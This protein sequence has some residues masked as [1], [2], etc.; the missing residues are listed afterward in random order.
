MRMLNCCVR[1]V[2]LYAGQGAAAAV[3]P[4][5]SLA[6]RQREHT[7][8]ALPPHG[9]HGHSPRCRTSLQIPALRCIDPSLLSKLR[10]ALE[11]ILPSEFSNRVKVR[12][13]F[14]NA[15]LPIFAIDQSPRSSFQMHLL[16]S[17]SRAQPAYRQHAPAGRGVPAQGS[18]WL[19]MPNLS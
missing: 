15:A 7:A 12:T 16:S 5:Q 10:R 6:G 9:E 4:V 19:G 14:T 8:G 17:D 11:G 1:L 18:G 3:A 2:H 13:A